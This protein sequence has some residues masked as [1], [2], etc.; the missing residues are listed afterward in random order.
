MEN[1]GVRGPSVS[2]ILSCVHWHGFILQLMVHCRVQSP[3]TVAVTPLQACEAKS[4]LLAVDESHVLGPQDSKLASHA[5][6]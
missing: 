3:D 4:V 5:V 6:F 1:T 2:L